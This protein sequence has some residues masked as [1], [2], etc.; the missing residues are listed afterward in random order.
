MTRRFSKTLTVALLPAFLAFAGCS[1]EVKDKLKEAAGTMHFSGTVL[2][3]GTA[4]P[5]DGANVNLIPLVDADAIKALIE[6]RKVP[7]GK[8]GEK[9]RVRIKFDAVQAYVDSHSDVVK[10]TT[11]AQGKFKVDAPT[12]LYLVYTFG[13]GG[14]P[15]STATAYGPHFWGI[16]AATGELTVD[17]LIGKDLKLDQANDKIQL[18]GGPVP[19][20]PPPAATPLPKA[21]VT[22]PAAP[23]TVEAL[24]AEPKA[25]DTLPPGNVIPAAKASAFW[26]EIKLAYD[27]GSIGTGGELEAKKAPLVEG[28]R[29]LELTAELA[30]EQTEPVYLVLQKGFDSTYV[31]N[32]DAKVSAATT[33]VYPVNVNGTKVTYQLV[34]P[35][36]FYKLYFAKTAPQ[37]KDGEAPKASADASDVLTVGERTCDSAIPD[38]PFLATLSWDK[39]G[40]IDLY[41]S[42]YTASKVKTAQTGDAIGE[43]LI[44]QVYYSHREGETVSLD[45]DNVYAYGPENNGEAATVSDISPYCYLVRV[46][47]YSG[48]TSVGDITAKVDVSMVTTEGGKKVVKQMPTKV[49]LKEV[50][51]WKTIGV[52]GP[53]ECLKLLNPPS[54]PENLISFPALTS[55][56]IDESCQIQGDQP[57]GYKAKITLEKTTFA[58][59]E[60]I[61]VQYSDMPGL[62]GDWITIVPKGQTDKSWCSWQW[63][64]GTSGTQWY[65]GVP[66]GDYEVRTYYGW[67]SGQC[68]VIGRQAFT[69]S[70]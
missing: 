49:T 33:R 46:N 6:Y 62:S 25:G 70:P 22:P 5:I 18:A 36:P 56:T 14:A 44:D 27:G 10:A 37:D 42:K 13:P 3:A 43:A 32:C 59:G 53:N 26:K 52:F 68:E 38:R 63:S 40:D 66:P 47:Y 65:G 24:Q 9:D 17:S 58:N 67:S 50:G 34:P 51:E 61:K 4:T 64:D 60:P 8:G 29:Y 48:D 19:A 55:C 11:D 30:A 69:V 16:D 54:N 35:G 12:N 23:A 39:T 31:A 45:V 21:D 57:G 2:R 15:G 7:D 41:V 28:Q 1:K 20:A